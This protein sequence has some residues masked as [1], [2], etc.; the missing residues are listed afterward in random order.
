MYEATNTGKICMYWEYAFKPGFFKEMKEDLFK[1]FCSFQHFSPR[2]T[3]FTIFPVFHRFQKF[4][5]VPM[6]DSMEYLHH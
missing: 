1:V 4:K 5:P 2:F 6:A 3:M